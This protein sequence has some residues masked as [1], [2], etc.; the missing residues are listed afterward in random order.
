M[1]IQRQKLYST[2]QQRKAMIDRV[3]DKLEKAG[4]EDF[5]VVKKI[6]GDSISVGSDLQSLKVYLPKEFEYSQ[7]DIDDFIR[8]L[9]GYI[10]TKTVLER[11]I[12]VM[13]VTMGKINEEQYI[14]LLKYIIDENAFVAIISDEEI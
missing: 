13:S 3:V 8:A 14:R 2:P 6:P 5:E 7:Y 9:P 11:D 12:Y 4:Y 10:R 1:I